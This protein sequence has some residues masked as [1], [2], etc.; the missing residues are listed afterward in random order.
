MC[1]NWRSDSAGEILVIEGRPA[2]SVSMETSPHGVQTLVVLGGGGSA[3]TDGLMKWW[4]SVN[5]RCPGGDGKV[6]GRENSSMDELMAGRES[7][8]MCTVE[9]CRCAAGWMWP[10]DGNSWYPWIM[11][12][13]GHEWACMRGRNEKAKAGRRT[14]VITELLQ[15]IQVNYWFRKTHWQELTGVTLG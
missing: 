6:E 8:L 9:A 10:A 5:L 15:E 2:L 3:E 13:G 12:A 4:S 11:T 14:G 1:D 7:Y